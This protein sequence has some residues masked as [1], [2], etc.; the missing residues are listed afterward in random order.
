MIGIKAMRVPTVMG[1]GIC[2][3]I[4]CIYRLYFYLSS[5]FIK[6]GMIKSFFTEESEKYI[7]H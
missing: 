4:Y 7:L 2:V 1:S 6:P 5:Y 3:L